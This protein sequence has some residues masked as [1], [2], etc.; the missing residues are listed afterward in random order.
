MRADIC[1]PSD[2]A[3]V[4][5]FR[6]A[7]RQLGATEADSSWAIGVTVHRIR[8]GDEELLVFNDSWSIDIEGPDTLV[9]RVVSQYERVAA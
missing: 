3:A 8:I 7:L 5:R 4:E 1:D 9:Q 6:A 2:N